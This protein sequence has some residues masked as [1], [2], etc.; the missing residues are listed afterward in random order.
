MPEL[1]VEDSNSC[2]VA[3]LTKL[4]LSISLVDNDIEGGVL[5]PILKQKQTSEAFGSS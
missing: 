2:R 3:R 4:K 1:A 5:R